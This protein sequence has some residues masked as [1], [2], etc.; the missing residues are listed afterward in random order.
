MV[1]IYTSKFQVQFHLVRPYGEP[2]MSAPRIRPAARERKRKTYTTI[3]RTDAICI[4]KPTAVK[5]HA[6]RDLVRARAVGNKELNSTV[7][8]DT[9]DV[10]TEEVGLVIGVCEP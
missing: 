8:A 4:V 7:T 1:I 9:P 10:A 2:F 6:K 5:R 3:G